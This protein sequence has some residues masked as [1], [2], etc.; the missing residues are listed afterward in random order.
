MTAPAPD[1]LAALDAA[2]RRLRRAALVAGLAKTAAVVGLATLAVAAADAFGGGFDPKELRTARWALAGLTVAAALR[3][4]GGPLLR[5][6]DRASLAAAA[7]RLAGG[8]DRL[9]AALSSPTAA[10]GPLRER[11][12]GERLLGAAAFVP[13]APRRGRLRG[14]LA[15]LLLCGTLVGAWLA[16]DPSTATAA[17]ARL[18]GTAGLEPLR[19]EVGGRLVP[20]GRLEIPLAAG[21]ETTIQAVAPGDRS[22]GAVRWRVAGA[23]LTPLEPGVV[24][25]AVAAAPVTV[26]ASA[27]GFRSALLT[28]RPIAAPAVAGFQVVVEPPG[29]PQKTFRTPTTVSVEPA[30]RVA[31]GIVAAPPADVRVVTPAG[32]PEVR[33]DGDRWLLR[34]LRPG[35]W[36]VGVALAPRERPFAPAPTDDAAPRPLFTLRVRQDVPPRVALARPAE[37]ATVTPSGT[38]SIEAQADDDRPAL[39]LELSAR[40]EVLQTAESGAASTVTAT[41][42]L[43]PPVELAPGDEFTVAAAA[44]DA[45]GQRTETPPRTVRVVSPEEKR[46]ELE[47]AVPPPAAAL[48]RAADAAADLRTRLAEGTPVDPAEVRRT[49]DRLETDFAA[50]VRDAVAEAN[51]NAVPAGPRL[52]A[53]EREEREALPTI[54]L[55]A[56]RLRTALRG[57]EAGAAA[58]EL[59]DELAASA[60]RLGEALADAAGAETA[61]A[62]REEQ[63]TLTE[64]TAA[65]ARDG[66]ETAAE[67]AEEQRT[68]A[69][70]LG[71]LR[72]GPAAE[73]LRT[74]ARELAAGRLADAV[75]RQREALA[76]WNDT[77]E[78]P[79]S[80]SSPADPAD[81]REALT[82]LAARQR[83]AATAL[84]SMIDEGLTGRRALRALREVG[85]EE[86]AIADELAAF[87][88]SADAVTA[89]A[90]GASADEARAVAAGV[91]D[92]REAGDLFPL[93]ERAAA[94]LEAL[95]G[96]PDDAP[97]T[98]SGEGSPPDSSAE[99]LDA[100]ALARWQRFLR[101]RTLAEAPDLPA[102]AAEQR[103]LAAAAPAEAPIADPATEAAARLAD[104]APAAAAE[105]QQAVLDLLA[106]L[107]GGAT[108][109]PAPE[110]LASD[111]LTPEPSAASPTGPEPGTLPDAG[112]EEAAVSGTAGGSAGLGGSS[113]TGGSSGSPASGPHAP[114][115]RLPAR[116]R[117][118]LADAAD[119]P[120][121]PG[122]AGLT[123]RYRARLGETADSSSSPPA[124][125]SVSPP[126]NSLP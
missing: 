93:A 28:L 67:L 104:G 62:L 125:P 43:S 107:G 80:D 83:A 17:A 57:G 121:A 88:G 39:R 4:L 119:A 81:R 109:S 99:G 27:D 78:A 22:I 96:G 36:P 37:G 79:G 45:R 120:A 34:R 118:R 6:P 84:R 1:P 25:V 124:S 89:A 68:I 65:A 76:R 31:V 32:G 18:T 95:A 108:A 44:T 94:R 9:A 85:D 123:A 97:P 56:D 59:S 14:A 112:T 60:G 24:R 30:D 87:A 103:A 61:E 82:T 49:L 64:R 77:A 35:D 40:G 117:E 5:R 91:E 111:P 69:T 42:E 71:T 15:A 11:L 8:N 46:D 3:W 55:A 53:A 86:S 7:D 113:G 48:R 73:A 66:G 90:A 75:A 10:A 92:R 122:F 20:R 2:G 58:K 74:A 101:D 114:W 70:A 52:A 126:S 54:R 63:L 106:T 21:T 72:D 100:D 50:P 102:L 98:E 115:G 16:A 19:L 29:R 47:A 110:P 105:R 41:V 51:R 38:T 26:A 33:R 12:L 116:L 23:T 13:P